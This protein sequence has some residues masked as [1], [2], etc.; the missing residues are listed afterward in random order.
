MQAKQNKPDCP[1][2]ETKF[3]YHLE[4][5]VTFYKTLFFSGL[6]VIIQK[7][8]WKC[9][10]DLEQLNIKVPLCYK[11]ISYLIFNKL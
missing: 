4:I 7:V 1:L 6:G 3:S 5:K 10:E 2:G 11:F 9:E 8:T